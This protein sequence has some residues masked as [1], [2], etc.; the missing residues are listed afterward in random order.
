M[1]T[2]YHK[3]NQICDGGKIKRKRLTA[4]KSR[5]IVLYNQEMFH[6]EQNENYGIS[7]AASKVLGILVIIKKDVRVPLDLSG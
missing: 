2:W 1:E 6:G 4:R 5:A 3:G 7:L